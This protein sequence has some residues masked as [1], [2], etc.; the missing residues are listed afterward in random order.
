MPAGNDLSLRL[1]GEMEVRRDG[2]RVPLPRSRKT[3]A[4]LAYLVMAGRS[5]RR[6]RLCAVLWDLPD[7]PRGE[8]RWSL[9]KVRRIVDDPDRKR[10]VTD[11]ESVSFDSSDVEIDLLRLYALEAEGLDQVETEEL[12]RAARSFRGGFLEGLTLQNCPEFQAWRTAERERARRLHADILRQLVRRVSGEPEQAIRHARKLVL[13]DPDDESTHVGLIRLLAAAGRRQEAEEQ[14]RLAEQ[15]LEQIG[16]RPSGALIVVQGELAGRTPGPHVSGTV[17]PGHALESQAD[18]VPGAAEIQQASMISEAERKHVTILVAAVSEPDGQADD[19][20]PEA[21][22]RWLDPA[23]DAMKGAVTRHGGTVTSLPGDGIMAL[24]GAPVAHEDHAARACFAALTM[25]DVL[26]DATTARLALRVGL[27]SGEVVV[28]AVEEAGSRHFEAV[29]PAVSQARQIQQ[30]MGPGDIGL[31]AETCARAEGFVRTQPLDRADGDDRHPAGALFVLAGR[32]AAR[33]RWEARAPLALTGFVGREAELAQI[34]GALERAD[35]G[36]GRVVAIVGEAGLGKSRLAHEFLQSPEA[37][38][39]TVLRAGASAHDRNAAYLPISELLR[40]WCEVAEMDSRGAIA[41]KLEARLAGLDERLLAMRPA[42]SS[43]LDLPVEDEDWRTSSPTKRRRQVHEALTSLFLRLSREQPLILWFEDL[44]WIDGETQAVLDAL[45]EALVAARILL[46]VTFRPEFQHGWAAKSSFVQIPSAPLLSAAADRFLRSLLG[47]DPGLVD[48]KLRLVER[49]GGNPLFLEEMVRA[50]AETGGLAG[51][52][53]EYRL[54]GAIDAIEMPATIREVLAARIDRLPPDGKA[55]LQVAAVIG[56]D[57]PIALLQPIVRL[58]EEALHERLAALRS[59]ELLYQS[60]LPPDPAV[61]FKHALT[62]EAAYEG[63]LREDRRRLHIEVVATI[64]ELFGGRLEEQVGRLAHHAFA[65]GLWPRAV[66]YF[67]QA[68]DK[69][70]ERSAYHEASRLYEQALTALEQLPEESALIEQGIDIRLKL[71]V[72]LNTI[73]SFE[74]M[75]DCLVKAEAL[76]ERI[77]DHGRRAKVNLAKI[78]ALGLLGDVEGAI[79]S[80]RRAVASGDVLG[81]RSTV[82]C[83]DLGIGWAHWQRGEAREA[84]DFLSRHQDYLA[85]ELRFETFDSISV[86]SV[87]CLS[88]LARN[89]ALLGDFPA[90]VA[91]GTRGC[92]IAEELGRPFDLAYAYWH[93]GAVLLHRGE[94]DEAFSYLD[95]AFEINRANEFGFTA[96]G[97]AVDLGHAHLLSNRA[98]EAVPLLERARADSGRSRHRHNNVWATAYLGL[99]RM[100]EGAHEPARELGLQALESARAYAFHRAE[101]L[102]LQLLGILAAK[103][104][105]ASMEAAEQDLLGAQ[106]IFEALG[107]LPDLIKCHRDLAALYRQLDRRKDTEV[108]LESAAQ[109]SAGMALAPQRT[110]ATEGIWGAC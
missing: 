78:Y 4:L 8:L 56:K 51:Q 96:V 76:A 42:L 26:R 99:A 25:R 58:G 86:R 44:H 33:S 3:R 75:L 95:Q 30:A 105:P 27:H 37:Q 63:V 53:G 80:G 45:V 13:I 97:V 40:A 110:A 19:P 100:V 60:R 24:F 68:G 71:R 102:A 14:Y 61:S 87:F 2:E 5:Q 49:S 12:E 69:A 50:L 98:P 23:L 70:V 104:G 84:V 6:D 90:A 81:T 109:L 41:A 101:A 106:G 28:R 34:A 83:A 29:G 10:I 9:S 82:A 38:G 47:D 7:D 54:T 89:Q 48:L 55:L 57:V 66:T 73:G 52:T 59:A 39:W 92:D 11:R 21:A 93:F 35:A 36:E 46:L 22:L 18:P 32:T 72:A 88:N 74:A 94:I 31:T 108:H 67:T 15:H 17:D 16:A 43:L 77:G 1:L 64:E 65:G 107:L 62:H 91:I 79:D 85:G 20:D 103:A